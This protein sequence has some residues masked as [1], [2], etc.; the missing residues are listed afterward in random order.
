MYVHCSH[1]GNIE[2]KVWLF[3]LS[4]EVDFTKWACGSRVAFLIFSLINFVC[5]SEKIKTFGDFHRKPLALVIV[6]M[7]SVFACTVH[8]FKLFPDMKLFRG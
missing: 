7:F 4:N 3:V 2:F 6:I 5:K 8:C 1:Q